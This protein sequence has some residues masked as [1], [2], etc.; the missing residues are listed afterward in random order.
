MKHVPLGPDM[1]YP[2]DPEILRSLVSRQL[3][4]CP[5]GRSPAVVVP[6]G[7]YEITA[8]VLAA[9][10]AA[11]ADFQPRQVVL[12]LP[13]HTPEGPE[14]QGIYHPGTEIINSPLGSHRVIG[15]ELS[16]VRSRYLEE[17][18]ALDNS[19]PFISFLFGDVPV[20]PLFVSGTAGRI[21]DKLA[22][23]LRECYTEQTLFAVS[24]N[25]TGLADEDTAARQAQEVIRLLTAPGDGKPHLPLL[26]PLRTRQITPCNPAALEAMRRCGITDAPYRLAAQQPSQDLSGKRVWYGGLF[27]PDR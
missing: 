27:H 2:A 5:R 22:K 12:L 6:H 1:F 4:R 14:E 25:L 23:L 10:W 8:P 21:A 18:P 7:F 15:R 26:E 17:E 9:A 3:D 20:L 19:L 11:A 13:V 16:P 24:T